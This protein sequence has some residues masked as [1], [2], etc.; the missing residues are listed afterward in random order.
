[1]ITYWG[2]KTARS[3]IAEDGEGD[4]LSVVDKV[5]IEPNEG[6]RLANEQACNSNK[7]SEECA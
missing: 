6:T 3:S 2:E 1:M 4:S 7:E 5:D